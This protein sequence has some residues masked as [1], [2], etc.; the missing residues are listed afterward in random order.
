MITTHI[1]S[2]TIYVYDHL[3]VCKQWPHISEPVHNETGGHSHHNYHDDH[4]YPQLTSSI[5]PHQHVGHHHYDSLH[6]INYANEYSVK[7]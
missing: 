6:Q 1:S 5:H 3:G 2:C 7:V 4:H